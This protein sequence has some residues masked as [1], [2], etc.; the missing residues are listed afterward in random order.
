MRYWIN[1]LSRTQAQNGIEGSFI[2]HDDERRLK[3]LA[4]GDRMVFYSPRPDQQF[5]AIGE[6]LDD[7]PSQWSAADP[8]SAWRRRV[9]FLPSHEAEIRPLIGQLD[10]ITNKKSWGFPFRRGLFEIAEADFFRI[11][12]AMNAGEF[13]HLSADTCQ[14]DIAVHA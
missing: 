7:A 2:E 14:P 13:G 6:V 3:R 4:M 8:G 12:K 5:I 10:F 11:A 9:C 1:T